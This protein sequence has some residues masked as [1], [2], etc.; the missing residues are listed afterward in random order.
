VDTATGRVTSLDNANAKAGS[1][2]ISD[3]ISAEGRVVLIANQD[4]ANT[5]KASLFLTVYGTDGAIVSATSL[6]SIECAYLVG[7]DGYFRSRLA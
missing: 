4:P 7:F 1:A 5:D 2:G 6:P 3:A